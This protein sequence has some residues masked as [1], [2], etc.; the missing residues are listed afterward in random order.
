MKTQDPR[1]PQT[2]DEARFKGHQPDDRD[3]PNDPAGSSSP[4][5]PDGGKTEGNVSAKQFNISCRQKREDELLADRSVRL[6]QQNNGNSSLSTAGL[7]V[8]RE[9][10]CGEHG[11]EPG[12]R[13]QSH[14][15]G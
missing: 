12:I 11:G 6:H 5:K 14:L 13:N 8:T 10:K 1:S 9:L 3:G 4:L 15:V 2:G 7:L